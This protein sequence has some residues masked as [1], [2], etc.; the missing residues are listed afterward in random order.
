MQDVI[1]IGGFHIYLFGITIAFGLLIGYLITYLEIKRKKLSDTVFGDLSI[2]VIIFSII[3][4]RLY[5]VLAFNLKFYLT[6]PM[7]IFLIRNGG[8][9]IQGGILGGVLSGGI[10]LWLKKA[11]FKDYAD[12]F[13]P[14]LAFGQ[15]IG[16]LGCDVFGIPMNKI[17]PWGLLIN[18]QLVH[19][20]QIYEA[21][22]DLI[23]FGFLWRKRATLRFKGQLFAEY[24]IGFGLIRGIV[25]FFRINPIWL[26]SFTVAHMTAAVMCIIGIVLYMKFK[27]SQYTDENVDKSKPLPLYLYC[28]S[29]ILLGFAATF[30]FYK[31]RF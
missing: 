19:P 29:I 26:G 30:F 21:L 3:G 27:S 5:Y 25:E 13:V 2:I 22:L 11:D 6:N 31:I 12:A 24:L 17:Y 1:S 4:A 20:V 14:G 18:G 10:Y 8:M 15:F 23:L 7:D 16:R 9:S 28:G